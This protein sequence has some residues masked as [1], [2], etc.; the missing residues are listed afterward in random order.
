MTTKRCS[1]CGQEYPATHEFFVARSSSKD[2]LDSWCKSCKNAHA[3][4]RYDSDPEHGREIAT[5]WREQNRETA[6]QRHREWK[7]QNPDKMKESKRKHREANL[8]QIR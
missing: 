8:E 3:K 4:K 6:R 7:N 2:G 1:K 5:R